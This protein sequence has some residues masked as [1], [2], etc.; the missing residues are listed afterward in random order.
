LGCFPAQAVCRLPESNR[1]SLLQGGS[2]S[3][4]NFLRFRE[5]VLQMSDVRQLVIDYWM[6]HENPDMSTRYGKQLK[7]NSKSL[8]EQTAKVGLGFHFNCDT[9]DTNR[10]REAA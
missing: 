4:R 1:L 3:F 6:G 9:R 5:A 7:R 8:T 10:A 2:V